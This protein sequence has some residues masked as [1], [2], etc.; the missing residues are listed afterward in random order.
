[1]KQRIPLLLAA[2]IFPLATNAVAGDFVAH[3]YLNA[4]LGAAFEQKVGIQ[5]AD[6]IDFHNGVRGDIA[7]G[8]QATEWFAA[9]FATGVIW[10]SADRIGNAQVT[11]FDASLDLYQIPIMANFI[12][13]T[14]S[15]H[16][17]KPY[18][19]AGGGGVAA[20]IDFQRPLGSIRDTDLVIG[21]QGFAGL[22]Y[23]IS[24]HVTAGL[25]YKYLRSEDHSWIENGVTLKTGGTA[26]HSVTASVIWS[27]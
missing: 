8:Y 19:G 12:F 4:D 9:E 14:P 11:S 17:F 24:E 7:I 10:N 21:Y 22:N 27:F 5:G 1:M 26:V 13:S 3:T 6:R 23:Q 16:G 18:L 20:M 2:G 15:W 25:G